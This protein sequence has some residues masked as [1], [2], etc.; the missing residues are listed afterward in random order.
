MEGGRMKYEWNF[1]NLAELTQSVVDELSPQADK[2]GLTFK[3]L[4]QAPEKMFVRADKDKLRQVIMNLIDNAIK[5]TPKGFVE[6]KLVKTPANM[7]RL[8]VKDSGVGMDAD[9]INLI[10]GKFVRGKKTPR[11]WTEGAG[12]GL[13]IARKIL[14]EHKGNVWAESEGEDKG[15]TFFVEIPVY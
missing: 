2:K 12:L 8:A 10:F 15:S 9:E 4:N 1:I 5:Y 3:Y 6:V 13:Y 11:L 7:A 14:E